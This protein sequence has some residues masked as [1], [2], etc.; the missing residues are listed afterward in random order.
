MPHKYILNSQLFLI[1]R[2]LEVLQ[3]VVIRDR[4]ILD[5][6]IKCH[7]QLLSRF[8]IPYQLWRFSSFTANCLKNLLGSKFGK[9]SMPFVIVNYESNVC[10]ILF[11]KT[12]VTQ[13]QNF[14]II[15]FSVSRVRFLKAKD[16]ASL[17]ASSWANEIRFFKVTVAD[18]ID[19]SKSLN[20]FT[21]SF[22]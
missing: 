11:P 22:K 21:S 7:C 12:L 17:E 13:I 19:I 6:L 1:N 9:P 18:L 3:N 14:I 8:I 20:F 15:S 10:R 4:K 2:I 16:S 5:L